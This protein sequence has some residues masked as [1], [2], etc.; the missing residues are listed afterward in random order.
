MTRNKVV[1][2]FKGRVKRIYY[3][4]ESSDFY[5]FLADDI[6]APHLKGRK[7][8]GHFFEPRIKVGVEFECVG[9]WENHPQYGQTFQSH[10]SSAILDT[11]QSIEKYLNTHL[12]SLGPA[13]A[14]KMVVHFGVDLVNIL[15]AEPD[16]ILEISSIPPSQAQSI[17]HE[18]RSLRSFSRTS[19]TL[20]NLG[21]PSG[22]IKQIY[23][24]FGEKTEEIIAENPYSLALVEGIQF[25]IADEIAL[26]QG[27]TPDSDVRI[28]SILEYL[29]Q[30]ASN[31]RGHLFLRKG[32]LLSAL[33]AL[34]FREKVP[35]YGRSLTSLELDKALKDRVRKKRIVIE[36]DRI[37]LAHNHYVESECANKIQRL[38]GKSNLGVDTEDFIKDYERIFK[39]KFS[40]AQ[41]E[42]I[43]ALN[44]N[45]VLLITGLPGTGKC[46]V[47][48]TLVSGPWGFAP[49]GDF[50][51][52]DLSVDETHDLHIDLDTSEGVRTTAY[53]YNGGETDTIKITTKSG[54]EI[55]GTPEHPIRVVQDGE[56]VWKTISEIQDNDVVVLVRGGKYSFGKDE[57]EPFDETSNHFNE[58]SYKFPMKMNPTVASLL[59]YIISEGSVIN[60]TSWAVTSH[61]ERVVS[62]LIESL[63][64]EFGYDASL[65]TYQN[66]IVGV[67]I[68]S[69]QII[70]W[71]RTQGIKPSDSKDQSIPR[72]ILR[73]S[74]QSVV[75]FLSSLFEGDGSVSAERCAIEYSTSS[76]TLSQQLQTI[77]LA[78]GIVSSRSQRATG[79]WRVSIYGE[80]YDLYRD[81]VGFDHKEMLER[82][83]STNTNK[84]LLYGIQP[85]ISELK[86]EVMPKKGDDYNKFYRNAT[87][88]IT[89]SRAHVKQLLAYQKQPNDLT[90]KII[91][92]MREDFFYDPVKTIEKGH[93]QVVDFGVPSNHEFISNGFISHNTTVTKALVRLFQKAQKNFLLMSPT[94]IAAKRLSFM[95][96]EEASTIHRA[97]GYTGEDN[98]VYNQSNML[99]HDAILVDE[100]SMIDQHL[101]YR[102][103]S[104]VRE[105]AVV[106]FVGDNAQLPSVGAGN[107]LHDMIESGV[108]KRVHL[109]EIFR[110]EGASDIVLNAHRINAGED[111][112]IGDPTDKNVDFR[113]IQEDD[114]RDIV[115]GILKVVSSLYKLDSK[116]TFQV[117]SPTYN[118][119]LGVD[120][121]NTQIKEVLNPLTTQIEH[122]LGNNKLREEDRIMVVKNDYQMNVFN[123]ELGKIYQ[124]DRLKKQIRAKI[125]DEPQDRLLEIPY[126][127]ARRLLKLSY[128]VTIHRC[129]H[130]DTIV[131]TEYGLQR[132]EDIEPEGVIA[133]PSGASRYINKV[134]NPEMPA[135]KIQSERGYGLT[136]TLDHGMDIW[137]GSSYEREDARN[138][139][140]GQ[141]LRYK[142]SI[143]IEPLLPNLPL[144]ISGDVREGPYEIPTVMTEELAELLGLL[145]AAGTLYKT[146][147]RLKKPQP[148]TV[149]RYGELCETVFGVKPKIS[150]Q[151]LPENCIGMEIN[152]TYLCRWLESLGGLTSQNKDVPNCIMQ[153]P[154]N[155]QKAFLRGM[156]DDGTVN[157]KKGKVD[158]ISFTL[159]GSV[160]TNKIQIMMLRMGILTSRQS[161]SSNRQERLSIYGPHITKFRNEIGFITNLKQERLIYYPVGKWTDDVIPVTPREIQDLWRDYSEVFSGK[162]VREDALT[163]G[164]L[165]RTQIESLRDQ[166]KIK[167][168]TIPWMEDRLSWYHLRITEIIPTKCE[169][170]C[171]EVPDG[172]KFL[173]NGN[174]SYNSQGQEFDYVLMPFHEQFSIQLQRNLLYTAVTRAKKKVFIF[175]QMKALN[176]AIQNNEVSLRN[177]N[178]AEKLQKL[179]KEDS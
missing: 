80:D 21:L 44:E 97:L 95:V 158:E 111:L 45:K 84:H 89:P 102:L 60:D 116:P 136:V 94:G 49:I 150:Y 119:A 51:P 16:R 67:R 47:P 98:W 125:F 28:S 145:V 12:T 106:V 144:P 96:G 76:K 41:E 129:V 153:S 86:Q 61:D 108:I 11:E 82:K 26:K 103:L 133:T 179:L 5:V 101:L 163:R 146:G 40:K 74:R 138:V 35:D 58:K 173:Q 143:T 121:L 65:H 22:K 171:V 110:Q 104:A 92:F 162:S 105:D 69:T 156:L 139:K 178:F 38:S 127:T 64:N 118:G 122:T 83:C 137:N 33:N 53:V 165:S 147:F 20:I 23:S 79:H 2:P 112:L 34:P 120:H 167:G 81:T 48:E 32:S 107:V 70:R 126:A 59:G 134:R 123:G 77:L 151:D 85:L 10:V 55:E 29:L 4:E 157:L 9:E 30:V 140:V 90:E 175:G 6:E 170:Y 115:Q 52:K 135:L 176:K 160:I 66:K 113:F 87:G 148:E 161:L 37:Y 159:N 39:I 141:F 91:S 154:S 68:N 75:A 17:I 130:P 131:E 56:V 93:S 109:S 169:S 99:T 8:R 164:H 14:R 128:A 132:I 117:L 42:A 124:I 46:V 3:Q 36:E 72:S 63:K 142:P 27:F 24:E 25:P 43:H 174:S 114:P 54:Y 13:A 57:L 31:Q 172:G 88:L 19:K 152:S 177:S 62:F 7:I 78:L 168:V 155:I 149:H 50:L 73:G 166:L 15:D 1:H 71:F 100:S 18:W